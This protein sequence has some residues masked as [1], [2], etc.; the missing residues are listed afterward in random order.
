M[1][2]ASFWEHCFLP[3]PQ[4]LCSG[5]RSEHGSSHTTCPQSCLSGPACVYAPACSSDVQS[6]SEQGS[7]LWW[8]EVES[9][10]V[11]NETLLMHSFSVQ[12]RMKCDLRVFTLFP[13]NLECSI[14]WMCGLFR[15]RGENTE[16]HPRVQTKTETFWARWSWSRG[17]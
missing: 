8:R 14:Y 1:K 3:D 12:S 5:T 9:N 13:S 11:P 4:G 16:N 15:P 2:A 10:L 6:H 7:P 17:L